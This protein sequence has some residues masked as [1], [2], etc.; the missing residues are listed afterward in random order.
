[1]GEKVENKTERGCVIGETRA[2]ADESERCRYQKV[3]DALRQG[4]SD[5][6][7]TQPHSGTKP[8]QTREKRNEYKEQRKG[9]LDVSRSPGDWTKGGMGGLP[10]GT[11]WGKKWGSSRK[12]PETF[13]EKEERE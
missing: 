3:G 13:S 6:A 7:F 12:G 5:K 11:M 10:W 8:P 2:Q 9:Q 4:R 1:V